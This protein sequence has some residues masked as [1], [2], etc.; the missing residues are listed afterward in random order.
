MP[1][2]QHFREWAPL[3][4]LS[5]DDFIRTTETRHKNAA[6]ALW[7]RWKR[8]GDIYLGSYSG[9]YSVRDEAYYQE[10]ELVNGKA[11]TGADVEWVE[12]PS[13]F[14][15]LSAFTDKPLLE[16]YDKNP[17]FVMPESRLNEIISFV[18]G[19]LKDLIHFAHDLFLGH[20]QFRVMTNT[21]CM[22]GSTR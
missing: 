8:R 17:E 19:G 9:W 4:N 22:S 7:K 12:E 5:N 1:S 2:S 20:V 3:L 21:S 16:F 18:K 13:Y 10:S 11:P 14:F 6:Q 15:K